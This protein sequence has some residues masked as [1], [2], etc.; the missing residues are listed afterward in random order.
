[1]AAVPGDCQALADQ[2]TSLEQQYTA[3]AAKV[4]NAVGGDAWSG[5][6]QLGA[7]RAQLTS[8]RSALAD[9]IKVHSAAVT[10]NVVLM[11]AS[12]SAQVGSQMASLWDLTGNSPV[13][14][15]ASPVQG[16]A[17]GFHGPVP[18]RAAITVATTGI[19]QITGVDFNSGPLNNV[20][21]S[22]RI[23][24]VIGPVLRM[25]Q[26]HLN[27]WAA[28]FRPPPQSLTPTLSATVDAVTASLGQ[29]SVTVGINGLLSGQFANVPLPQTSYS[30]SVSVGLFPSTS[31]DG[32]AIV[33][34]AL[35]GASPVQVQLSES[36]LGALVNTLAPLVTP[37]VGQLVRGALTDWVNRAI[38]AVTTQMLILLQLPP[39]VGVTIRSIAITP[40]AIAFQPLLGAIGTTLSTFHAPA[41]PPP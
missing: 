20:P 4:G 14:S 7:L 8:V 22:L 11:D 17:F 6:A 19:Q 35:A 5:L 25:T 33:Q 2:V 39:G 32:S 26:Q 30:A 41:V 34:V 38:P 37:I 21:G 15:E 40:D 23:E 28:A 29:D 16:A 1:M 9:C 10:G 27:S 3:L 13:Q 31:V 12:G 18:A 36:L 24:V